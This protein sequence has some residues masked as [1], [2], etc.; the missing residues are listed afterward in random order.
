MRCFRMSRAIGITGV[1]VAVATLTVGC[2]HAPWPYLRADA[3]LA[4]RN[5]SD[6][7]AL[8]REPSRKPGDLG[9]AQLF[10]AFPAAN[11]LVGVRSPVSALVFGSFSV[12]G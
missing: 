11:K 1:S 8:R 4:Q 3:E 7:A 9:A 10:M 12:C 2:T 5:F 6:R